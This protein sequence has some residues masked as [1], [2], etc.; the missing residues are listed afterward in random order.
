MSAPLLTPGAECGRRWTLELQE[1]PLRR[2]NPQTVILALFGLKTH[3]VSESFLDYL[4]PET[5]MEEAGI[6]VQAGP[7]LFSP[8]EPDS[9]GEPGM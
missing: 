3:P 8:P 1:G 7:W 5:R 6:L 9:P 2:T 4:Y